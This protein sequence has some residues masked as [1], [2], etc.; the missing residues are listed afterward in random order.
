MRRSYA[1]LTLLFDW[2]RTF[3]AGIRL[4]YPESVSNKLNFQISDRHQRVTFLDLRG[5]TTCS[6]RALGLETLPSGIIAYNDHVRRQYQ[7][8]STRGPSS[9]WRFSYSIAKKQL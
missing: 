4:F 7:L 5:P 1:L 9:T 2:P 8:V 3:G 6:T